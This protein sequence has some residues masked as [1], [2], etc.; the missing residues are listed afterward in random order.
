[1]SVRASYFTMIF[2]VLST[3]LQIL[4]L[5]LFTDEYYSTVYTTFSLGLGDHV[6]PSIMGF[7]SSLSLWQASCMDYNV[8]ELICA[9]VL[10]VYK[11]TIAL[12][13]STSSGSYNLSASRSTWIPELGEEESFH[14][15]PFKVSYLL[16]VVQFVGIHSS[17]HLLREEASLMRL[18]PYT[19]LQFTRFL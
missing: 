5:F 15:W 6:P 18:E 9:S 13:S 12:K 10:F 4:L 3:Y 11:D 7:L 19:G 14:F 8:C 16:H 1:M 17:Y 2:L